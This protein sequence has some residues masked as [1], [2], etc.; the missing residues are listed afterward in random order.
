VVQFQQM[1]GVGGA[2]VGSVLALVYPILALVML[3]KPEV[4][5]YLS[6]HGT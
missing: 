6:K 4:K 1:L 3:G 2:V 5:D